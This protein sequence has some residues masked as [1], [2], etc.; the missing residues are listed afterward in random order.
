MAEKLTKTAIKEELSRRIEWF[1][2]AY[3]FNKETSQK[4]IIARGSAL[5]AIQFGR[6]RILKE[7]L[8]QVEN[9]GFIDGFSC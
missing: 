4:D 5:L 3:S 1:E 6:Y 7:M 2:T 8:W 9:N